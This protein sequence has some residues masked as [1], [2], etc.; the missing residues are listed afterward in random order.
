MARGTNGAREG[1]GDG[2]RR[3]TAQLKGSFIVIAR[4]SRGGRSKRV[5]ESRCSKIFWATR[6][7]GVELKDCVLAKRL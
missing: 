3:T 2:G 1:E 6:T 5:L 7:R 4:G